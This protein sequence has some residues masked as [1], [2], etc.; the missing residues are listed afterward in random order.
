MFVSTDRWSAPIRALHTLPSAWPACRSNN[1][2]ATHSKILPPRPIQCSCAGPCKHTIHT[3]AHIDMGTHYHRR[4][5]GGI[6]LGPIISSI[7]RKRENPVSLASVVGSDG[8]RGDRW[9]GDWLLCL[10]WIFVGWVLFVLAPP[11]ARSGRCCVWERIQWFVMIF[12]SALLLLHLGLAK[13]RQRARTHSLC[14][15]RLV[16]L[17]SI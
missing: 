8:A 12:F 17:R 6:D 2:V 14:F 16:Q 15:V 7:D 5:V 11:F 10:K 1:F 4:P 13:E 9:D 3:H